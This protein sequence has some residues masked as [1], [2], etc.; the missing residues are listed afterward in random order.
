[1]ALRCQHVFVTLSGVAILKD[2]KFSIELNSIVGI[3]GANGSGK[4]TLLNVISGAIMPNAGEVFFEERKLTSKPRHQLARS[5]LFRSFQEARLFQS[6]SVYENVSVAYMPP[7][8]EGLY[9]ALALHHQSDG[10]AEQ[11][12]SAVFEAL[13][14][15]GLVDQRCSPVSEMSYGFRKRTTMAQAMAAR[16]RLC[17]L[18]EPLAGLDP[19]AKTSTLKLIRSLRRTNTIVLVVEHDLSAI[20]NI[21]DRVLVLD[22]GRVAADG[23]VQDVLGS[24]ANYADVLQ[25]E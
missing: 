19:Q 2:I 9:A 25:R 4:T 12:A 14:S 7:P 23:S 15:A 6:L 1:M 17:L 11:R 18:D 16:P 13:L 5:G 10:H 3:I 8:D 24:G 22:D 20:A 21:A